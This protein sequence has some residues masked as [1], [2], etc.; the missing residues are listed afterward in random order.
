MATIKSNIS[1]LK[2]SYL[3][4]YGTLF[5]DTLDEYEANMRE[6]FDYEVP[7]EDYIEECR[8]FEVN[9][10]ENTEDDAL[11]AIGKNCNALAVS[12]MIMG[13]TKAIVDFNPDIDTTA[14][15][16][17]GK[18]YTTWRYVVTNDVEWEEIEDEEEEE[19]D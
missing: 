4:A 9:F 19:E 17:L 2:M 12:R 18:L 11:E 13:M 6:R 14:L 8:E 3:T 16:D 15:T 10:N 5:N 7:L 1:E